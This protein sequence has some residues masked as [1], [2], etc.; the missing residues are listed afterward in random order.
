MGIKHLAFKKNNNKK[1]TN[2]DVYDYMFQCHLE[3]FGQTSF[4]MV[5]TAGT[6]GGKLN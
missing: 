1:Q 5:K 6:Y 2:V 3:V 4:L